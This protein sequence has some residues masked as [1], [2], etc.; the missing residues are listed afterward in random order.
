MENKLDKKLINHILESLKK[1]YEVWNC[2][3]E[4]SVKACLYFSI[5]NYFLKENEKIE[6]IENK[7]FVYPEIRNFLDTWKNE[8][9]HKERFDLVITKWFLENLNKKETKIK[10]YKWLTDIIE[11]KYI[12]WTEK[13]I[14][15]SLKN[16]FYKLAKLDNRKAKNI[17][18][19]LFFIYE[20]NKQN[21]KYIEDLKMKINNIWKNKKNKENIEIK[22][23]WLFVDLGDSYKIETFENW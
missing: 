18:K 22:I 21:A 2:Y 16:D 13:Q 3:R 15:D 7:I 4:D 6:K 1:D 20:Y 5:R 14:L 11:I 12:N 10:W 19:N 23:F 9:S 17:S 8:K